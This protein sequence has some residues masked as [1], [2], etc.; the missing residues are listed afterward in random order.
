[1]A[2]TYNIKADVVDVKDDAPRQGDR[3]FVDTNVWFWTSYL[4]SS[5]TAQPYQVSLYPGYILKI[6]Q[7][8][9]QI[10][11]NGLTFA[12]IASLI[13]HAEYDIFSRANPGITIK[14]YRHN[15]PVERASAV[16][17]IQASWDTIQF[18][19]IMTDALINASLIDACLGRLGRQMLDGSDLLMV[20]LM[21]Q[22]GIQ[23]IITDDGDFVTVPG[24]QV[25][26]ANSNVL[27]QAQTQG[28]LISRS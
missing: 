13:E 5:K 3:F 16:S 19:S 6:L 18:M 25:F 21:R 23:Q 26:T 2:I 28:K 27:T 24:L 14:E 1:M 22:A 12:E 10:Y 9:A 20:E 7:T 17:E 4:K 11:S 8:S 15:Y